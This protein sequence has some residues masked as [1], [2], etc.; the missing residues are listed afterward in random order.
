[1]IHDDHLPVFK[2]LRGKGFLIML[3]L[4]SSLAVISAYGEAKGFEDV[5]LHNILLGLSAVTG[6]IASEAGRKRVRLALCWAATLVVWDIAAGLADN[7]A[8]RRSHSLIASGLVIYTLVIVLAHVFKTE[9]VT[10]DKIF[11]AVC[12]Y[13][14]LSFFWAILYSMLCLFIGAEAFSFSSEPA[15]AQERSVELNY[16]SWVTLSTLGYG[17]VTPTHPLTRVAAGFEVIVGQFYLAVVV[18][19]L[20]ALQMITGAEAT[21]S[22]SAMQGDADPPA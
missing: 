2:L 11:G 21:E 15:T 6:V 16:Y 17:D 22:A 1:M 7:E 9:R 12:G 20:V 14:L 19:R 4:L 18:A 10:S 13:L 3:G 8:V 5:P